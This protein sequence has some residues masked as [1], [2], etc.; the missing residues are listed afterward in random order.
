MNNPWEYAL[1]WEMN[2]QAFQCAECGDEVK[3]Y[4]TYCW[5]CE[6]KI[7]NTEDENEEDT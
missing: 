1:L 5:D 6:D 7:E 2:E 3:R 4:Q